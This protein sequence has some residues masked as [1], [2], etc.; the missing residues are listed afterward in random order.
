MSE[1]LKPIE[2]IGE[3]P[4]T[5]KAET[6]PAKPTEPPKVSEVKAPPFPKDN[7]TGPHAVIP[8]KGSKRLGK[9]IIALIILIAAIATVYFLFFYRVKL[10]VSTN[11]APDNV[12]VDGDKLLGKS[13]YLMPGKHKIIVEKNGSVSYS[14]DR[15]FGHGEQVNLNF[16][17]KP[18]PKSN[19]IG[20]DTTKLQDM[21]SKV[22]FVNSDKSIGYLFAG[23]RKASDVIRA[24][25]AVY[26]TIK[27]YL[28]T[29]DGSI[30]MILDNEAIK[31]V[32]QAGS[33]I[34][35]QAQAKLPFKADTIESFASNPSVD[36]YFDGANKYIA[37][38]QTEGQEWI[39][40]LASTDLKRDEIVMNFER[41]KF[42]N[43]NLEWLNDNANIIITGGAIGKIELTTRIYTELS[44][45]NNF[46]FSKSNQD[47]SKIFAVKSDGKGVVFK[48]DKQS[49]IIP[50]NL[51]PVC[52][53]LDKSNA[54]IFSN[55]KLIE[56]NF[57]TGSS[58]GYAGGEQI[59]SPSALVAQGNTLYYTNSQ[60]LFG[61]DLVKEEY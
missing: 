21:G 14:A 54:L 4:E 36:S 57:D 24:T 55:G 19:L 23:D 47:G 61:L 49:D 43:I 38:D 25:N 17:F 42:K 20:L 18:A 41:T 32:D 40:R 8:K 6:V 27:N 50:A 51:A 56:Y 35:N 52:Y 30:L 37:F 45:E 1:E 60:G 33:D 39:L 16:T 3:K 22:F 29:Q 46:V 5:Q 13:I 7:A 2:P 34:V 9:F 28:L 53:F 10:T 15:N 26:P 44:A 11:P 48:D 31:L 12:T 58:I 59:S